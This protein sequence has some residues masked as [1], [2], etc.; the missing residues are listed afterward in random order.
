MGSY[1]NKNI[2]LIFTK[3]L[4]DNKCIF[5]IKRKPERKIPLGRSDIKNI[6]L[7][8][9]LYDLIWAEFICFRTGTSGKPF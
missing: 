7:S 5:L 9:S 4:S 3:Y 6:K 1:R 2:L 8:L